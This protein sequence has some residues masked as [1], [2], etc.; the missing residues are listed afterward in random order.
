MKA[1]R[2]FY[3]LLNRRSRLH[4]NNKLRLF[5]VAIRPIPTYAAPII[6]HAAASHIKKLQ[7]FQNKMLRMILDIRWN[8]DTRR[9]SCNTSDM[10]NRA[11]LE[12]IIQY[13]ERVA[14]NY[15]SRHNPT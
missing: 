10:H 14:D 9:H 13:M 2:I 12:T 1:T 11:G 6:I 4:L 15:R 8:P 7:V 5:R 3:S